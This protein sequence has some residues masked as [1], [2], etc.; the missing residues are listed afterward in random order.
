MILHVVFYQPKDTATPEE[1]AALVS[2]LTAACTEIPSVQQVR[3]GKTL[4][5]NIG[6]ENRSNGQQFEYMAVFEFRDEIDLRAYLVH[7]RHKA[8]GE[9][10]WKVCDRTFIADVSAMDPI[11]GDSLDILVKQDKQ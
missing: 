4:N 8:L 7:D 10:F 9:L 6:Y 3:V 2:A 1:R 5:L 11:A